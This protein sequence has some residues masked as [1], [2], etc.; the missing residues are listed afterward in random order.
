MERDVIEVD[1]SLMAAVLVSY[2]AKWKD[3]FF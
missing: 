3:N 1:K 2:G